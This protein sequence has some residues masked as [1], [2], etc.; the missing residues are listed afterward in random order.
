[1]NPEQIG[2]NP[3]HK[4]EK[5]WVRTSYPNLV[6]NSASGRLYARF[7]VDG[8]LRWK[9]LG[10]DKIT[11]AKTRLPDVLKEERKASERRREMQSG[12]MTLGQALEVVLDRIEKDP[13]L[14]PKTK[15]NAA[16]R[17]KALRRAWPGLERLNIRDVTRQECLTW[18]RDVAAKASPTRF[19][20]FVRL[21]RWAFD[22]AVEFG[23][24]TEN[25][26]NAIEWVREKP[27]QLRLP[28][29]QQFESLVNAVHTC[30]WVDGIESARF[31]EFLAYTGCR[32]GEAVNVRWEDV[33]FASGRL[34][35]RGDPETGTKNGL[36]RF[37]PLNPTAR[38]L[39]ERI[40]ADRPAEPPTATVLRQKDCRKALAN[41]CKRI[42]IPKMT[43]HDLRHLFATRCIESGVD[44]PTVSRWLGHKD[45]GALA[46][47]VYGHLRDEHSAAMAQRVNFG[48][49]SEPDQEHGKP[50]EAA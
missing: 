19:N 39:L 17:G 25:S 23:I 46:M 26:A 33:D 13:N 4:S 22:V 36:V 8:K 24:R 20:Q 47:R 43:H 10:T 41:A 2:A 38:A 30:G 40:R 27:K 6:R 48:S 1:V 16:E 35:V 15:R 14:K 9:S 32:L 7:R 42:G 31:V 44:I 37:V 11:V 50:K 5:L 21:L 45:G 28:E 49:I 12:S 3:D 34:A 18:A 29:P